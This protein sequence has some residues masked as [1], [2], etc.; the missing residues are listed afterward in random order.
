MDDFLGYK[1]KKGEG[2]FYGKRHD[3]HV[4]FGFFKIILIFF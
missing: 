2:V 3:L 4:I 1:P